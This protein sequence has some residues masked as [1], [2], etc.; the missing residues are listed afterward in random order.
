MKLYQILLLIISFLSGIALATETESKTNTEVEVS[1][2]SRR[3]RATN[4]S[5]ML[6]SKSK[7]PNGNNGNNGIVDWLFGGKGKSKHHGSK[8]RNRTHHTC[9]IKNRS[10]NA[11]HGKGHSKDHGNNGNHYGQVWGKGSNIEIESYTQEQSNTYVQVECRL[12][13]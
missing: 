7:E 12:V 4:R 8:S 13:R 2:A 5:R 6:K 3:M 1:R 9:I 11:G 10:K